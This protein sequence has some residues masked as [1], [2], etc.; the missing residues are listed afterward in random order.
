MEHDAEYL[1]LLSETITS[2]SNQMKALVAQGITEKEA[3]AKIDF[4]GVEKRYTHD[5]PFL[6][7]RFID[8]VSG[9]ALAHAAYMTETAKAPVEVF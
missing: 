6:K 9:G 4:S 2:V 5:D 7:N 8:Y 3:N 1:E